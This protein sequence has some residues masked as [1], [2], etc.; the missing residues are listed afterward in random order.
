M[1]NTLHNMFMVT[2]SL[3]TIL[4]FPSPHSLKLAVE[5][6]GSTT[7]KPATLSPHFDTC[8]ESTKLY[9]HQTYQDKYSATPTTVFFKTTPHL[10]NH[11]RQTSVQIISK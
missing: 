6:P 9:C 8:K 3:R 10:D 7:T 2:I 1:N 4:T 5:I 11:T